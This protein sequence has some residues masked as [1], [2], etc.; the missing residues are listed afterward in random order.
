MKTRTMTLLCAWMMLFALAGDSGAHHSFS[1]HFDPTGQ[2]RIQ[3][4]V[5]NIRIRSPHSFFGVDVENA[6]GTTERWQVE[7][8]SVPLL[9]RVNIDANTFAIGQSLTISG[10]PSRVPGRPLMF[11]LVFETT[12]GRVYEWAPDRLVPEGGLASGTDESG[13]ERFEGVW[14]YEADPNPHTNAESPYPLTQAGLDA[15][16]RFDPLDTPA[17]HCIPPNLPSMLYLPYLYGIEVEDDAVRFH[18]E[19]YAVVRT[20]PMDGSA[21]Q[22]ETSGLFG[23]VRGTVDGGAIVV[24]SN[25]FPDLLA[26]LASDFDP[27]GVGADV[28]SSARK[29]FTER[30]TLS[31]DGQTLFVDYTVVDP[32]YLTES[33]SGRTEWQRLAEGTTI[34]SFVCDPEIAAQSTEG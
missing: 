32:V 5:A 15:R 18:H 21:A 34:E 22:A 14:G 13:L 27:N 9:K 10:M 17:M 23:T 3:G 29:E 24:R 4:T 16:R 33:Y 6:D 8:H 2:T 31:D 25:G 28:P 19:Y 30:Y 26:G 20:V 1:V 12:E 11:G 7:T